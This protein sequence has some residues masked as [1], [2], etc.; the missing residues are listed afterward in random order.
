M[1]GDRENASDDDA[2]VV[3]RHGH[4]PYDYDCHLREIFASHLEK[5]L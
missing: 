5:Y 2:N 3:P 4:G 1:C